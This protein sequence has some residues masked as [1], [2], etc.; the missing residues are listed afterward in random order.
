MCFRGPFTRAFKP[1]YRHLFI[2]LYFVNWE[3][4]QIEVKWHIEV[5]SRLLEKPRKDITLDSPVV[6]TQIIWHLTEGWDSL[7]MRRQIKEIFFLMRISEVFTINSDRASIFFLHAPKSKLKTGWV[8]IFSYYLSH[9]LG[10]NTN[11]WKL[12]F[13]I[14][15]Y[16]E[17]FE[18]MTL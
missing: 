9:L 4:D 10:T 5:N 14:N 16:M 3:I 1:L 8:L 7:S 6:I 11:I 18:R 12:G 2:L 17:L 15:S 13:N